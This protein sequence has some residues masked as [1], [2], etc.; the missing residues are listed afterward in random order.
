MRGDIH[1]EGSS[2]ANLGTRA[3]R[4]KSIDGLDHLQPCT[5]RQPLSVGLRHAQRTLIVGCP[6]GWNCSGQGLFH[7][8]N[9]LKVRLQMTADPSGTLD[10]RADLEAA[11]VPIRGRAE[12]DLHVAGAGIEF[13]ASE[14][15]QLSHLDHAPAWP[16]GA[17]G[18]GHQLERRG[19]RQH[20]L[21]VKGALLHV[22]MSARIQPHSED[23]LARGACGHFGPFE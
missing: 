12:M 1:S 10:R 3:G 4:R 20:H 17:R 22:E 19:R 8:K 23:L 7:A 18:L 6:G 11:A 14:H 15:P 2:P 5:A 9:A 13:D 21:A 16:Y